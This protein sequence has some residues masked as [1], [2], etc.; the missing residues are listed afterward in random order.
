[1]SYRV[2][3]HSD[4]LESMKARLSAIS[5][6]E[7]DPAGEGTVVL[8]P[9]EG[10]TRRDPGDPAIALLDC[11]ATVGDVLTFYQERIAN[12]GYL[13]TATERRSVLELARLVGYKLRPGVASTV[14]LAYELDDNQKDPVEIPAGAASQSIPGPDEL[15]QTFE[16]AEPLKARREWNNLQV[17]KGSRQN[18]QLENSMLENTL[19]V[20]G[21]TVGLRPGH[22]LLLVFGPEENSE[23]QADRYV[24]RKVAEATAIAEEKVTKVSLQPVTGHRALKFMPMLLRMIEEGKAPD[25][26]KDQAENAKSQ[27]ESALLGDPEP[28]LERIRELAK[29]TAVKQFVEWQQ[30]VVKDLESQFGLA[31]PA[32]A[33]SPEEFVGDLL[34]RPVLQAANSLKL[35]R[36]LGGSFGSGTDAGPQL[37]LSLAPGLADSFYAAWSSAVVSTE[38]TALKSLHVFR[39]SAPLFGSNVPDRQTFKKTGEPGDPVPL[40]IETGSE[41]PSAAFLD[42]PYEA[43]LPGSYALVDRPWGPP[44]EDFGRRIFKITDVKI[45]QRF[46]YSL[47]GKTTQLKLSGPWWRLTSKQIDDATEGAADGIGV[48]RESTFHVQSEPLILA[49][50]PIDTV[51]DG[52]G[53]ELDGLYAELKSGRRLIV[54]G[55]RADI[56][57]VEG[58]RASELMMVSTLTHGGNPNVPGDKTHTTLVMATSTAHSYKRKSVKIYANVVKATHGETRSETMGSGDGSKPL[59]TFE[60]K[61][62]PLTFVPAPT[63]EG[64]ESTLNVYVNDVEW[65][66][67]ETLAGESPKARLFSTKTNDEG[68][69]SVTFGDGKQGAR[70]PTGVENVKAVYRNGIGGGGNVRAEQ[71]SM[72]TTRPLGVKAVINPLRASGGADKESRDQARENAPLAVMSLDRLVSVSDYADF[73]RTFAGVAKA[74]A[75]RMSDGGRELVHVTIAGVEDG[76]I[77]PDSDLYANLLLA[78]R[79]LGDPDLALSI[80]VR[81]LVVLVLSAKVRLSPDYLWEPVATKLRATLLDSFGFNRAVLGEPVHLSAVIAAMHEVEGVDWVDVDSFGGIPELQEVPSGENRIDLRLRTLGGISDSVAEIASRTPSQW[82]RAGVAGTKPR[83][84]AAQL[85]MFSPSVP[86]TLILQQIL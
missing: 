4:F 5:L 75:R 2:G 39:T 9:L 61:Q 69:T 52:S 86:D 71:V 32:A 23:P 48:L 30:A 74:R 31:Q 40:T 68:K 38:T 82:V 51:V 8:R 72:L 11:W 44:G 70:L 12:E 47:G 3:T 18:L 62:P 49:E 26:V 6:E 21:T 81:E 67:T 83:L 78:L 85:A 73:V 29:E 33:T 20:E 7:P 28:L 45:R 53:I 10:L 59:Q 35:R 13:G 65:H 27:I 77:D 16:T 24:I 58:V 36:S 15:P 84:R 19:Y 43:V 57:G 60:L 50:R 25:G 76:P 63:A 56:P 64:V 54:S 22:Q 14:F 34:Q 42:Q 41:S 1:M 46:A 55:E 37:L 66:E 79:K 80:Q 17:R